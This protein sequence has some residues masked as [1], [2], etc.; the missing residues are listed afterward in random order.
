MILDSRLDEYGAGFSC[1]PF[2]LAT[3][4][5]ADSRWVDW[6]VRESVAMGKGIVAMYKGD[7]PPA[8]LPK[9]ITE[10]NVTVVPWN[11]KELSKA[12]RKESENR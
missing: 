4:S 1:Y 12:I 11:Q 2:R 9:S 3:D 10:N 7:T 8:R 5:I 6:E